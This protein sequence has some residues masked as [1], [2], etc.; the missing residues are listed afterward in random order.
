VKKA[1]VPASTPSSCFWVLADPITPPEQGLGIQP[2]RAI[3]QCPWSGRCRNTGHTPGRTGRRSD[4]P[5][6]GWRSRRPPWSTAEAPRLL[7]AQ[8]ILVLQRTQ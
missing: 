4:S 5:P 2:A 1:W 7:E 6:C 8:G 3:S